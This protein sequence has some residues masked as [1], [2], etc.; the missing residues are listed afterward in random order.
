MSEARGWKSALQKTIRLAGGREIQHFY[1]RRVRW[2]G[3]T[4][5]LALMQA[6]IMRDISTQEIASP[7]RAP[8]AVFLQG[9][10]PHLVTR[11]NAQRWDTHKQHVS[12][13]LVGG[14]WGPTHAPWKRNVPVRLVRLQHRHA[15]VVVHLVAG[16]HGHCRSHSNNSN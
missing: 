16:V 2:D 15:P 5:S 14:G 7:R 12:V 1:L 11:G 6:W 9:S 3:K 13:C 10:Y 4:S 8:A